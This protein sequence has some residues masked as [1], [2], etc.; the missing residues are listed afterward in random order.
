VCDYEV[1]EPGNI[2][3]STPIHVNMIV[4]INIILHHC[5]LNESYKKK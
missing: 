2:W 5:A 3:D 1:G 4:N